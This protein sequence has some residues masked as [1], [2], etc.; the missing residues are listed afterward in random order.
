MEESDGEERADVEENRK[1]IGQ[2]RKGK[3]CQS[4][5]RPG[6]RY[7]DV[8]APSEQTLEEMREA[9]SKDQA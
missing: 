9:V 4:K 7:C 8:H 3:P 1:C 5:A 6:S 2:N